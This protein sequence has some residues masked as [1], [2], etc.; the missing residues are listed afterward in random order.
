MDETEQK[1]SMPASRSGLGVGGAGGGQAGAEALL[2]GQGAVARGQGLL[3]AAG[4]RDLRPGEGTESR[5][6]QRRQAQDQIQAR[7][8][9]RRAL[10]GHHRLQRGQ[11]GIVAPPVLQQDRAFAQ[12]PGIGAG[13]LRMALI[14]AARREVL[15]DT[16]LRCITPLLAP[17]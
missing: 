13:T 10:G 3:Q 7:R 5:A 8:G 16:A 1:L 2:D 11:P 4:Q 17:R 14:L 9:D 6:G 12:G 15:R